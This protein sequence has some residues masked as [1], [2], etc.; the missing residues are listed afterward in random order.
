[1]Q[2]SHL[3]YGASVPI[4]QSDTPEESAGKPHPER[5][6]DSAV[7]RRRPFG[8]IAIA[9]VLVLEAVMLL[10]AAGFY[11]YGLLTSTPASLGGAV[12]TLVLLLL[13]AVWLLAVGHF[14]FRGYRWTRAAAL[15]WQL[16]MLVLGV[17]T[18]TGGY[19]LY[20]LVLV[21][22]PLIA[23]G[24]LFEKAVVAYVSQT[25]RPPAAL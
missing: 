9:F 3:E 5:K 17:P 11:I 25:A 8:V 2:W 21:V 18:L 10:G 4:S 20:G 12:F 1:M 22:P 7:T 16:F 6:L 15:V 14:L 13:L 24:L 19:V 23:L